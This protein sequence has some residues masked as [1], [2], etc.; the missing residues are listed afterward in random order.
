[1]NTRELGEFARTPGFLVKMEEI[2]FE[3]MSP[4]YTDYS[5]MAG[6]PRIDFAKGPWTVDG[7]S[8]STPLGP[9]GLGML[10]MAYEDVPVWTLQCVGQYEEEALPCLEAALRAA[11]AA[12]QFFG[13]RGPEEFVHGEFVYRNEVHHS[14][15]AGFQESNFFRGHEKIIRMGRNAD[16]TM[17]KAM[18]WHSYQGMLMI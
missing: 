10:M 9:R 1:M 4:D 7:G 5:D 6:L 17:T 2:F 3:A 18:G 14:Y 8:I 13:G 16:G 15:R 12:K 11:Y